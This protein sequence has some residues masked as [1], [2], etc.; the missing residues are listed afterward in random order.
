MVC[1]FE[2]CLSLIVDLI[3]MEVE[4]AA[5]APCGRERHSGRKDSYHTSVPLA[6]Y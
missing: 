4:Q 3:G 5:R 2:G 1:V 6:D